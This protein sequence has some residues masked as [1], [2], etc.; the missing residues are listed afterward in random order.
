MT[1]FVLIYDGLRCIIATS[2]FVVVDVECAVV[3]GFAIQK[4]NCF[5]VLWKKNCYFDVDLS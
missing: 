1:Q 5:V 4:Y 2:P 3:Q